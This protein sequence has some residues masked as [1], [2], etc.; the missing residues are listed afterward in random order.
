[1]PAILRGTSCPRENGTQQAIRR[2]YTPGPSKLLEGIAHLNLRLAGSI[3]FGSVEKV[4]SMVPRS[5]HAVFDD[6][7]LLC[8]TV[9]QP[10][11]KRQHRNL[12][13]SR[14]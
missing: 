1:M 6:A 12:K 2:A 5:L 14:A 8:T 11:T 3:R 13:A 9:C 7:S 10:S 4:D